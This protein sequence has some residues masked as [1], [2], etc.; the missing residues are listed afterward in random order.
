MGRIFCGHPIQPAAAGQWRRRAGNH[1]LTGGY[2]PLGAH[3]PGRLPMISRKAERMEPHRPLKRAML[4]A[5]GLG[6]RLRPLTDHMPKCMLQVSGR[7]V[8]EHNI[9][10]LKQFGIQQLIIN[11]HYLPRI[12]QDYFGDGS[13]WGN[14]HHLFHGR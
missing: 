11:L 1:A 8:L 7:P 4:L 9:L 14:G 10:W 6:T 12:V 3:P 13:Q 5:A 2:L